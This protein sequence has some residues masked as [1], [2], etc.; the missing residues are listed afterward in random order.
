[1][2]NSEQII[3]DITKLELVHTILNSFSSY[4][5]DILKSQHIIDDLKR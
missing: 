1:M 4:L 3:T 2:I 5:D